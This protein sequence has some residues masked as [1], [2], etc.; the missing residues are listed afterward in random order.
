MLEIGRIHT[1]AIL[2]RADTHV[3]HIKYRIKQLRISGSRHSSVDPSA[4][5]ILR[6]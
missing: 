5:T 4:P 6:P 3:G 2:N 1:L